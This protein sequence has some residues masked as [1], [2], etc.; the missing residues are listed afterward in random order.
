MTERIDCPL[1]DGYIKS[2]S[3]TEHF[4]FCSEGHEFYPK[5]KNDEIVNRLR[6]EVE[7]CSKLRDMGSRLYPIGKL[8]KILEGEITEK[9]ILNEIQEYRKEKREKK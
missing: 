4:V 8:I 5:S 9:D 2:Y 3:D 7:K 1:C 6:A